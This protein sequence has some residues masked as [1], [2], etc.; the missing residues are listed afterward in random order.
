MPLDSGKVTILGMSLR[1]QSIPGAI[2]AG[3]GL[4]P[5]NRKAE[6]IIGPLSVRD[7]IALAA[8]PRLTRAGIVS[9][10]RVDRIV[11]TFVSRLRIK[12]TSPDQPAAELSGGSQQKVLLARWLAINPHVL[13]LDEPTRGIDVGAKADVQALID[14]LAVAGLAVML[15]SSDLEEL[16]ATCD[17]VVVLR[18]GAVVRQL[19]GPDVTEK[20][21]ISLLAAG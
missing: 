13:M 20:N 12:A 17:R 21:L 1:K 9:E 3:V 2:R 7:N 5:Q 4:L 14:D 19:T 16:V 8:L 15:I 6:G 18:D 10:A 11:E